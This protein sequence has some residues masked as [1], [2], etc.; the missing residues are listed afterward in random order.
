MFPIY[1]TVNGL[2]KEQ[3]V[4]SPTSFFVGGAVIVVLFTG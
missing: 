4:V 1:V 2:L 3:L